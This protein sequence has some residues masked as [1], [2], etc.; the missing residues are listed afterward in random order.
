MKRIAPL[1][2]LAVVLV[3][4]A[5]P[6]ACAANPFDIPAAVPPQFR[7]LLRERLHMPRPRAAAE[8]RFDLKTGK[9]YKVAVV[10]EG[11]IVALEVL[12]SAHPQ[13]SHGRTFLRSG[14]ATVYVARGTVSRNRISASFGSMGKVSVRFRPSGQVAESKP[15]RHCR[16]ADH[17][18]S[19]L[20]VYVGS[21]RFSGE[22]DYLSLRAHRAKGRIRSPLHLRCTDVRFH[23]I[24]GRRARPVRNTPF[25]DI[26]LLGASQRHGVSAVEFFALQ[27]RQR[28]LFV[29]V[30]EQGRG[31]MAEIRYAVAV[32]ADKTFTFDDARTSA[33]LQP[34]APFLGR[35]DYHAAADGTTSW[36]GSLSAS[37]PGAPRLPLAGPEFKATLASGL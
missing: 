26:T 18:T 2:L 32:A 7:A 15:R 37:F 10:A 4:A 8:Y 31:R 9:G 30:T 27:L 25:G 22:N 20:G 1:A 35:G 6:S 16:G 14:A 33:T 34:P 3:L 23:R 17:F 5:L 29:A 11:D 24:E 36:S 28:T 21:I 13:P 19:D 12:R